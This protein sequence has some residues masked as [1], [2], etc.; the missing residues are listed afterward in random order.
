M[1]KEITERIPDNNELEREH[2]KT[3]LSKNVSTVYKG[4]KINSIY[5]PGHT[6]FG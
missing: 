1:H 4:V 5:T 6:D 2:G 3:I